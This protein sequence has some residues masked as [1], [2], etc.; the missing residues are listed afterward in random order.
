VT[1]L[2]DSEGGDTAQ[3]KM[4]AQQPTTRPPS[5]GLAVQFL[6]LHTHPDSRTKAQQSS[7]LLKKRQSDTLFKGSDIHHVWWLRG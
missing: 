2:A 4:N 3:L 6:Y 7:Q 1:E 5:S